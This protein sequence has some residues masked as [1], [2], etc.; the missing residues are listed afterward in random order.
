MSLQLDTFNPRV[1]AVQPSATLAMT[2]RAKQLRR[3]GKPVISL[4]AGE[5]D[6]DTP[7]PIAE[8][9][10][11]AIREGF[12]HYTENAGMLELREA[13]CRKLAEENGLTYEPD[14]ILC[15]NGA[16]QA[17][18]MAIEVLCRP[19]DEVLIPAPY[20]VSYPEMVR[21]AG[22]TPVIL[23]TSVETG[24]R[25]TPEQLEAAITER[26]RLLI[27]CSP[28]NPTGT[29]YAPEE[30]E[31]LA[32]VLRRHEHV[33]VL[34]DEIYE[35]IL[36]DARHVSFASLPG[37]KERTITV[38]GFSKGFAMTGWRLGYLAAERP[39]VKAAA[40]VQSQFTSA[41]CSISQ[42]AGLAALQ[43][44]KGPIREM[45]AA[46]RQRR[47]FMLERL[48]AIDG[49]TCPKPEGAFYLFPQVS[50]FYGR[51]TPDG[52]TITDSESLCLYLLEQC[53]VALVPGQAFGDPNGVRISYAASMENLA[54]AMRRIE[55]GLAALQ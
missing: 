37:M 47:D 5:P 14:Q 13:I 9:A 49:I 18:A 31:A 1:M 52:R 32:D 51:R 15:T 30:L 53:H 25:L 28:S 24:Y 11:Q 54:E 45:V 16:K 42:K 7:A 55:A 6:F 39:I 23:P 43:M 26:T 22:A 48:Q 8:A 12:T 41:P 2:A 27:L 46:F 17:V 3:E 10:I 20:W 4:S 35:Y 50:A 40:K 44:D 29:V 36:F 19:E 34:S 33:Y 38:N 21:L